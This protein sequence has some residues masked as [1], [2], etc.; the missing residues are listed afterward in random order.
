MSTVNQRRPYRSPARAESARRNR[1]VIVATAARLFVEHGYGSTSLAMIAGEAGVSRPTVFAAFGSKAALLRKVLDQAL[2]GDDDD[3]P[4]VERPWFKPVWDAAKPADA[5]AAYADVCLIIGRR[6][7][8]LFETVRR[9]ADHAPE[10]AH[11]WATLNKN[12]RAGAAMVVQRVR[13]LG[14]FASDEK[15]RRAT[16]TL[17]LLNDPAHYAALV[18]ECGWPEDVFRRWLATTMRACDS[19]SP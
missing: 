17:W 13:E 6:A 10:A 19:V 15:A 8:G 5:L 14:G 7:A 18:L 12:R 16:D 11:L 4:V 3:V 1:Q 2:A 9:A